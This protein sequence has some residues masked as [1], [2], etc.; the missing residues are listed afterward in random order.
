FMRGY[1][2]DPDDPDDNGAESGDDAVPPWRPNASGTPGDMGN[3]RYSR[4]NLGDKAKSW[5]EYEREALAL[6]RAQWHMIEAVAAAL[7]KNDLLSGFDLDNIL[8]R[9]A[10]HVVYRQHLK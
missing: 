8:R 7:L 4:R 2:A 5:P 6:V 1:K 10:R 3:M 9:T